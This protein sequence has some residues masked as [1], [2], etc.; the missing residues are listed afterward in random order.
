MTMFP[1][2]DVKLSIR[3]VFADTLAYMRTSWQDLAA[4]MALPV[5]ALAILTTLAVVVADSPL[6]QI[7]DTGKWP[8]IHPL[9]YVLLCLNMLFYI[10]FSVACLRRRLLPQNPESIG[11]ALMWDRR[12]TAFIIRFILITLMIFAMMLVFGLLMAL[13][14]SVSSLLSVKIYSIAVA[15]LTMGAMVVGIFLVFTRAALWLPA[16]TVDDPRS[17]QDLWAASRGNALRLLVILLVPD[18]VFIVVQMVLGLLPGSQIISTGPGPSLTVA[19]LS[20]LL[21]TGVSYIGTAVSFS[22]L[23][24]A[25]EQLTGQ[26]P[27]R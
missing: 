4:L 18:V 24:A 20:T 9:A 21:V 11:R 17:L 22:M 7:Q 16:A 12:K 3:A 19:L 8:F 13:M 1:K 10:M 15:L 6:I 27:A 25:Y 23:A 2:P 26:A 5:V 14:L